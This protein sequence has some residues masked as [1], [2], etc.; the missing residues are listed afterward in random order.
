MPTILQN[1]HVLAVRDLRSSSRFFEDL[2]FEAVAEHEGWIFVQRDNCM[3]MLGE[4]LDALHPSDLGDHS[5]FGYLR[6]DDADGYYAELKDKG[7][8]VLSPVETKPWAMREFSVA[9]PEGHRMT[10]GQW[11]GKER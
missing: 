10:I 1:H 4:C 2:G 6:V 7:V 11:V 8:R 9:S 3:V 5:Y